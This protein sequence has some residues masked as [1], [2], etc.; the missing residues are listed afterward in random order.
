M[1]VYEV[2]DRSLMYHMLPKHRMLSLREPLCHH[3]PSFLLFAVYF[4]F[5]ALFIYFLL[6]FCGEG[7]V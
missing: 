4:Q 3:V 1:Y 2:V 7:V 5:D 6:L